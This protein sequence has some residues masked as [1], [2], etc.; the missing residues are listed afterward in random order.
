MNNA[1]AYSVDEC[2]ELTKIGRTRIFAA[3]GSGEL[4]A[5]KYGR[6]TIILRQDLEDFLQNRPV[7]TSKKTTA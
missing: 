2:V 1:L 6:R 3:L 7:W 4:V 5:R